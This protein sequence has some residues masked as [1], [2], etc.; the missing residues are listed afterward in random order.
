MTKRI[1]TLCTDAIIRCDERQ[2]SKKA[3]ILYGMELIVSTLIGVG[4]IVVISF[5]VHEPLA[6]VFFLLAFVPLRHTAGGY[7]AN[8]H[9]Q[10]YMVVTAVFSFA[11]VI[12]KTLLITIFML[13]IAAFVSSIIVFIFSP[14]VPS[15][16]PISKKGRKRNRKLSCVLIWIDLL[17][18]TTILLSNLDSHIL[19]YYYWGILSASLSLVVAK[20]KN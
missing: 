1:A 4:L 15:N 20:I 12:E 3:V 11:V 13:W 9:F 10:C 18:A 14:C 5:L 16:K 17:S 2:A 8:T 6:W 19:H 7:H